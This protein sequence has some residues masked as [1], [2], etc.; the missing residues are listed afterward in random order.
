M[1]LGYTKEAGAYQSLDRAA[2]VHELNPDGSLQIMYGIDGRHDLTE[3]SLLNL[4]RPIAARSPCASAMAPGTNSSS[5]ST[6]S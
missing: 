5:T 2:L 6:A 3:E 1:R 4:A